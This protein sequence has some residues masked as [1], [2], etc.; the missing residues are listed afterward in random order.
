MITDISPLVSR[1]FSYIQDIP[2]FKQPTF[3]FKPG[4]NILFGPNGCGK[5]TLLKLIAHHFYIHES[6]SAN[7]SQYGL[8][9]CE[10]DVA[11][12]I[13][14]GGLLNSYDTR[15]QESAKSL[16]IAEGDTYTERLLTK[17]N[18]LSNGQE[19]L[20]RLDELY[21]HLA[22]VNPDF[23]LKPNRDDMVGRALNEVYTKKYNNALQRLKGNNLQTRPTILLD[24][25]D[26][27]LDILIQDGIWMN[28]LGKETHDYQLII[29][30]HS[31]FA[32]N[33]PHAHYIDLHP[34]YRSHV[35][36]SLRKHFGHPVNK[37]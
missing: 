18:P 5:S 7:L 6:I 29:A 11:S 33:I 15:T 34:G 8:L 36:T 14:D 17:M 2:A 28:C 10:E 3:E 32:L 23:N 26:A 16:T 31:I 25:P 35:S 24:E 9:A 20:N 19:N 21:G 13:H 12:I 22:G 37:P 30:T 27:G 4:L 1:K